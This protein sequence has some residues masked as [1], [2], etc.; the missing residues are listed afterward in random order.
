MNAAYQSLTE[1]RGTELKNV[2][3]G[4]EVLL[5]QISKIQDYGERNGKHHMLHIV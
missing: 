3:S 4:Q 5:N 1:G 2:I